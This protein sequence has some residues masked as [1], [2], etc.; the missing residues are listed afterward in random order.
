MYAPV[1]LAT[2]ATS[3]NAIKILTTLKEVNRYVCLWWDVV[4]QYA[5]N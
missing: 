3:I 2:E 4:V 1:F 5:H